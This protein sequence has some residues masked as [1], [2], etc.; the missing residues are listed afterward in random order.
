MA[1]KR[2]LIREEREKRLAVQREGFQ[3]RKQRGLEG[4]ERRER[5][6]VELEELKKEVETAK[7]LLEDRRTDKEAAESKER[8]ALD[9]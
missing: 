3:K 5:R 4:Q 9:K 7:A 8:E 2:L 6:K 1:A